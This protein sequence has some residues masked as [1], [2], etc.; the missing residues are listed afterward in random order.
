[1]DIH[2]AHDLG[3]SAL[4]EVLLVCPCDLLK[5]KRKGVMCSCLGNEDRVRWPEAACDRSPALQ[6]LC[7]WIYHI[8][9]L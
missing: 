3:L 5:G 8:L 4:A 9:Y 2:S 7:N 6:G 1:M